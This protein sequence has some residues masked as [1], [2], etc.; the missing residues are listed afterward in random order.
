VNP[1]KNWEKN[2]PMRAKQLLK[3][4][5]RL[6]TTAIKLGQAVSI[7]TDLLPAPYVQELSQLQ[8]KV[9]APPPSA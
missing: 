7:R 2:M 3:I 1:G 4:C 8:D 5:T 6:G 9:Q